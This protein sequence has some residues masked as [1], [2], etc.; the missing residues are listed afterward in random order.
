MLSKEN[1]ISG[2]GKFD[3]PKKGIEM[4]EEEGGAVKRQTWYVL[5][6]Y[7][8]SFPDKADVPSCPECKTT[9]FV[10][11]LVDE[12]DA[13][14]SWVCCENGHAWRPSELISLHLTEAIVAEEYSGKATGQA[15]DM[16]MQQFLTE[17]TGSTDRAFAI[18][19]GAILDELLSL[20]LSAFAIDEDLLLRRLLKPDRPLGSFG[21]RIDACYVFGLISEIEWKALRVIQRIRNAFAHRLANLSFADDSMSDRVHAFV[22]R[23]QLKGQLGEDSRILFQFGVSALWT[24]LIGKISLIK[25]AAK[26]P[27]D[28]SQLMIMHQAA[29]NRK[30]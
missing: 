7:V 6:A 30:S 3:I 19:S 13:T 18:L 14:T 25:R 2:T 29:G 9:K 26:M 20:M 8:A 11:A 16:W 1:R 22:D 27:F 12:E 24:S 4:G 17:A 21:S 15:L 28:P 23:L 5:P 10:A